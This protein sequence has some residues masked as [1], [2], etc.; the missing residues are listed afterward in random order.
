MQ[1]GKSQISNPVP[2]EKDSLRKGPISISGRF[3]IKYYLHVCV[4]LFTPV[5]RALVVTITPFAVV[6]LAVS[7]VSGAA[8]LRKAQIW[9]H[10]RGSGVLAST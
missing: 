7:T 10:L 9:V 5:S 4:V 2:L 6:C 1:L 3:L 8:V